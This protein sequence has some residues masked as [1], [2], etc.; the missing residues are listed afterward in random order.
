MIDGRIN[1]TSLE[2]FSCNILF[3]FFSQVILEDDVQ[4]QKRSHPIDTD[5][6]SHFICNIS[7]M[8]MFVSGARLCL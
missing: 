6:E 3:K 1:C 2:T 4:G 8:F 5:G 7:A